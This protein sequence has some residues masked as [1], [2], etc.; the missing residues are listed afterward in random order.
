MIRIGETPCRVLVRTIDMRHIVLMH[1]CMLHN[2]LEDEKKECNREH[3]FDPLTDPYGKCLEM[4]L[5]FLPCMIY[6]A[7]DVH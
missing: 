3:L 7:S 2:L 4:V 6:I 5:W 1:P